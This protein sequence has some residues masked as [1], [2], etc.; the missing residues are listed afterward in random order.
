RMHERVAQALERRTPDAAAEIATHYD[1]GGNAEKAYHYAILAADRAK[2][3]YAHT[4]GTDFLRI[5]ERNAAGPAQLAEVRVRLAQIAELVGQYAEAQEHCDLAIDWFD[6]QGDRKRSL[7]LRVMRERLRGFLGQPAGKSLEA[8]VAL[9]REAATLNLDTVRVDLLRMISLAHWRLGDAQAAERVAWDC[10]H[11]AEKV[12]DHALLGESL[13]RLG[14]ALQQDQPTQS[15]EI[16]KRA[17]AMWEALGDRRGQARCHN[18]IGVAYIALGDWEH[19]KSHLTTAITL[20][21]TAGTPDLWGLAAL[22]LGV[23]YLKAG[24]FDRARELFGEALAL[25]AAAKHSERQLYALY[26]LAH[27]DHDRHEYNSA[28]EL[29]DV[30]TSLAQ[31]IGQSE[32]EIGATAGLGLSL[33]AQG[34]AN[35]AREKLEVAWDRMRSRKDWFQGR[36]LVEALQV[37]VMVSEGQGGDALSRFEHALAMAD[38]T[39]VYVGA[40]LTAACAEAL[41]DID[42]NRMRQLVE[43]YLERLKGRGYSETK[44]RLEELLVRT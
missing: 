3:V 25:F 35:L 8:A 19:A 12:G 7:S 22:N 32:V 37:N 28:A 23:I 33:L 27:L 31:R 38:S 15:L 40:W 43:T 17:L 29:Y 13:M 34:K 44:R 9:E 1:R 2:N 24:E 39:D 14:S 18:T 6:G 4:E 36:E 30:T 11:L 21:R 5:A 20:G 26:N 16:Q 42:S 10:V 41:Y